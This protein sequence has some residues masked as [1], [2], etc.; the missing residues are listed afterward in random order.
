MKRVFHI[1]L[2]LPLIL[3]SEGSGR[4]HGEA[5]ILFHSEKLTIQVM[6]DQCILTGE[7]T[8]QNPASAPAQ[9]A[10]YYPVSVDSMLP[11][12]DLF[13][14]KD[15]Y[16]EAVIRFQNQA[17]GIRFAVTIPAYSMRTFQVTYQQKCPNQMFEYILISTSEWKRPLTRCEILI[18]MP[19]KLAIREMSFPMTR[20]RETDGFQV[21]YF[22]QSRFQPNRNLKICWGES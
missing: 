6:E 3:F 9:Q 11:Y 12:P 5:A 4:I 15:L 17:K 1:A 8:F 21:Y 13:Q 20:L 18:Y 16:N 10:L 19:S 2:C 7:Y 22:K 14:V